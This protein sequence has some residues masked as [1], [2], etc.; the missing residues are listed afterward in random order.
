MTQ[1]NGLNVKLPNSQLNKIK[2][3]TKN[4]TVIKYGR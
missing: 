1:Y 4:E 3:A 2:S